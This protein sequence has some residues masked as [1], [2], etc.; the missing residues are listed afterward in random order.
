MAVN[1]L[2][3]NLVTALLEASAERDN[4]DHYVILN[5]DLAKSKHMSKSDKVAAAAR[6]RYFKGFRYGAMVAQ[7]IIT[8]Q[9][10]DAG[11]GDDAC[12]NFIFG[13]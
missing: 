9:L 2:V 11:M 7:H 8:D 12:L 10:I 13:R 4:A 1:L 6:E 5:A 3:G